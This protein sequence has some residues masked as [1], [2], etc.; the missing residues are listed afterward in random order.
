[1]K[2][3]KVDNAGSDLASEMSMEDGQILRGNYNGF[4][5]FFNET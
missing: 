4:S 1:M 5:L 3:W 2:E